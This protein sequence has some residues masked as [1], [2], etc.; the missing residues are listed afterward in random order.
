MDCSFLGGWAGGQSTRKNWAM[1]WFLGSPC[2]VYLESMLSKAVHPICLSAWTHSRSLGAWTPPPPPHQSSWPKVKTLSNII[3]L[4]PFVKSCKEVPGFVSISFKVCVC[5][6]EGV[7]WFV[8]FV[9]RTE[10]MHQLLCFKSKFPNHFVF[11]L[12][13][14]L[15]LL[16]LVHFM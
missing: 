2:C 12:G 16:F 9:C 11:T 10:T 15:L 5:W 4:P 13:R 7:M 6:G 8:G 1:S 3:G 14:Y